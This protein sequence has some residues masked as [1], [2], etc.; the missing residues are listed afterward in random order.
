MDN[1][2]NHDALQ[3]IIQ[4]AQ[5]FYAR[6]DRAHDLDHALRVREWGRKLALEEGA[7]IT[8][9]E[10]AALLHDIGRSGAVE[11]THAESSAGLAVNILLKN[12]YSE[13]IVRQVR[14]AIVS[15]SREAGHEPKTLEAKILYDADKLDFVGAIGLGRLFI[16]AGV[17]G[18][19]LVGENSCEKFYRERI[20]S[21][22]DHLFTKTA[23]TF[24]DPLFLY[25]EGFWQ[26]LHTERFKISDSGQAD[27][28]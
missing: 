9:V 21:Y 7:D 15:H 22:R 26:Q 12:G 16:W 18:W 5:G 3:Q 17:Q 24:F 1:T 25:M 14:E 4:V 13:E 20:C 2:A 10:L 28:R 6:K 11:R 27:S 23:Q 19:T 8:V